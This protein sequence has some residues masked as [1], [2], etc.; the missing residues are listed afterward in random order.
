MVIESLALLGVAV[1]PLGV[2]LAIIIVAV[3]SR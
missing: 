1:A 2:T 3:R